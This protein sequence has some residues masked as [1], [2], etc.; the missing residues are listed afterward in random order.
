MLAPL[1]GQIEISNSLIQINKHNFRDEEFDQNIIEL[2]K[3]G[4][5][6]SLVAC[7]VKNN[8]VVWS[9][10]YGLYNIWENKSANLG[11]VY[12]I[13][14]VS[15]SVAASSIMILNESGLIGLD[16]NDSEYFIPR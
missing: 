14:S 16:D 13:A 3:L 6:P 11:I 5:M 9:K 4:H 1:F 8:S 12:P 2:M 10:A 15:K 7:I